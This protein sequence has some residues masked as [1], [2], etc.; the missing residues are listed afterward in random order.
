MEELD[1]Q[2]Q[3]YKT[4]IENG[5]ASDVKVMV[6]KER[7]KR[8]F[9]VPWYA[10]CLIGVEFI[11]LADGVLAWLGHGIFWPWVLSL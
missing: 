9:K 7:W 4:L 8:Y 11:L 2:K 10:Y 3:K 5:Y 6:A 1:A